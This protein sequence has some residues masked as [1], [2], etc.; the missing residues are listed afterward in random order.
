MKY[1]GYSGYFQWSTKI[2]ERSHA[3]LNTENVCFFRVLRHED[4]GA[5]MHCMDK[6]VTR[7]GNTSL[8]RGQHRRAKS[9]S[10]Q[11]PQT[12]LQVIVKERH[13]T[14]MGYYIPRER[15]ALEWF[16]PIIVE[17]LIL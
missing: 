17:L 14:I 2:Y 13:E 7:S 9:W 6:L 10:F 1:T 15:V 11:T 4:T 5:E 8:L 16:I 12:V 3:P